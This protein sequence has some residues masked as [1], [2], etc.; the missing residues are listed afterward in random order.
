MTRYS[1]LWPANGWPDFHP[2]EHVLTTVDS[3]ILATYAGTYDLGGL[4]HS[5]SVKDGKLST[6]KLARFGETAAAVT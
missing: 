6:S 2:Q 5:V 3:T 1:V 4:K